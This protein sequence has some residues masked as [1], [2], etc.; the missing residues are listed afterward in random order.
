MTK[1][2]AQS[3]DENREPILGVLRNLFRDRRA[4]LEIGSGTGQH[5]VYFAAQLPHLI[6]HTSDV[7]ENHVGI[8]AWLDEA[9]LPNVEPPLALDVT[10]PRWP[11]PGVDAVF[12]AN[13]VHIMSWPAVEACF[14]G[15]G[16]LLPSGGLFA[17]YGPFN[18]DGR[19]TSE[20]NARFDAWLKSRDPRSGIRDVRDLDALAGAAR[21][22]PLHDVEM[23][24][25]NRILCWR[26]SQCTVS[27]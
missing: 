15:V 4:V 7:A 1:P 20:S 8:K 16:R 9:H 25:N 27:H 14:A 21:L 3:C 23:P 10:Q 26:K 13:T 6:W 22:E 2:Y 5:A 17:L 24:V 18:Y 19:Y 11:T 12:S